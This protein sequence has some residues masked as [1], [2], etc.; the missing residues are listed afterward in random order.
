MAENNSEDD[1]FKYPVVAH[2]YLRYYLLLG[3]C[4]VL[5]ILVSIAVYRTN[6][7]LVV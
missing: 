3:L 6:P 4:V 1:Y 7:R 2:L 5:P